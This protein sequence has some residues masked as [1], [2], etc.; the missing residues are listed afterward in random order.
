MKWPVAASLVLLAFASHPARGATT[1]RRAAAL[2]VHADSMLAR[3][4]IDTRRAA[5]REPSS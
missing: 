3:N 1:A 5:L 4:T 2:F